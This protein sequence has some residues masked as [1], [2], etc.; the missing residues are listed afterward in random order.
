M[1][2]LAQANSLSI[3]GIMGSPLASGRY[4]EEIEATAF[5][6]PGQ[7][8]HLDRNAVMLDALFAVAEAEN[9]IVASQ[10]VWNARRLLQLLPVE[11]P[12]TDA[13]ISD[14]ESV[15]FDWDENPKAQLSLMVQRNN[16][17]A[18]A[19]YFGGDR[20]NGAMAF[21]PMELPA[22]VSQVVRRWL[23]ESTQSG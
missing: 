15:C 8:R 19:A 16:K 12:P 18:F 1:T 23:R 10:T 17:L 6:T 14:V 22:E 4:V 3:D 2:Y 20:F 5:V 9:M 13:H 7:Q 21:N 11:L